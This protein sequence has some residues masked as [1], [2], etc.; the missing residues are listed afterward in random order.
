MTTTSQIREK[1]LADLGWPRLVAAVADRCQGPGRD[2]ETLPLAASREATERSLAETAE[3]ADFLRLDTPLPL[4][5]LVDVRLPLARLARQGVLT[6]A[7]LRDLYKV[8]LAATTLRRFLSQNKA[9]APHLLMAC[10]TDPTLDRLADDLG[11]ALEPDGSVADRASAQLRT[12]R[13]E[14]A[15][16]RGRIVRRLEQLLHDRQSILQEQFYTER[17]GRFVV[18]VR[19]DAHERLPGIVHGT[20]GSGAT[21]FVEPKD[22]VGQGNRL[23]MAQAEMEREEARILAA[24]SDA[25]RERLAELTAAVDALDHADLRNASARLGADLDAQVLPL[26]DESRVVLVAA[27][28]PLLLLDGVDVV[29]NDL[30][31]GSGEALVLSG[32][33][34]G[35]KTVAL[36]LLGL[37]ALMTRAGLPVPADE[38]SSCAFFEPILTDVGDEQSLAKNL[39]TFSA[40]VTNV[41]QILELAAESSLVLLDELSGGTDPE[42]G[43]ALACAIVDTLCAQGAAV[44]VTTH[45]EAL[46]AMGAGDDRLR[47]AAVG[48][49][50]EA[51]APTFRLALDVP[52]ASSAL[53]VARRFGIPAHVVA[54]A[55]GVL[56]E[57]SRTFD[58]LVRAL[59]AQ[60]GEL[61]TQLEAATAARLEADAARASAVELLAV[62]K[63]KES[64]KLTSEGKRLL[65]EVRDARRELKRAQKALD[66]RDADRADVARARE[67]AER[68]ADAS[69]AATSEAEARRAPELPG[70]PLTS[71][72][73]LAVGDSVWVPSL[74]AN[75]VVVE[76]SSRGKVR[77]AAGPMKLTV[78]LAGLR[79]R[80][81]VAPRSKPKLLPPPP[82]SS[83]PRSDNTLDVRGL[84]VDEAVSMTEAFLDRVYGASETTAYVVHGFGSGALRGAI[85]E[86]L[87]ADKTYVQSSRAGTPDEGGDKV[88]IVTLK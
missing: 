28:H 41:A 54:A 14:V 84:R 1:T 77:V 58:A 78:E 12:L 22:L 66:K 59:E 38:G 74:R 6:G 34:A 73:K 25:V 47:N 44:A 50:V 15:N 24:L 55:E 63:G 31:L 81:Q 36:K 29:P 67:V 18:P 72:A 7:S 40:H 49:D 30:S 9:R 2:R 57:Q 82:K 42:E 21:V 10:S 64:D 80:V 5:G 32:P 62:A 88:T 33:N 68:A 86:H 23:K 48:F 52:G 56:P 27:R 61:D 26:V 39:S 20:S 69:A 85:R 75:A 19:R 76:A 3:A 16:L 65:S 51:M 83:A 43:A 8:L 11:H 37:A 35:G 13:T 60:R 53:A 70:E 45:Y 71:D 46:K 87:A 17:E 4:E 79:M